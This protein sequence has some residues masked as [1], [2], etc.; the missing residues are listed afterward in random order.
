MENTHLVVCL[1]SDDS[2]HMIHSMEANGWQ[3]ISKR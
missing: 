2:I 3:A 1:R